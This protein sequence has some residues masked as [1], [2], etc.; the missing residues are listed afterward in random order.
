MVIA[1]IVSKLRD[2]IPLWANSSQLPGGNCSY[3]LVTIV[4]RHLLCFQVPFIVLTPWL[5]RIPH[6]WF[7]TKKHIVGLGGSFPQSK[8]AFVFFHENQFFN[9]KRIV[10]KKPCPITPWHPQTITSWTGWPITNATFCQVT[11]NEFVIDGPNVDKQVL[12]HPKNQLSCKN[13]TLSWSLT[14]FSQ[15]D[16]RNPVAVNC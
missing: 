15:P 13:W 11:K 1:T 6:P 12:C 14:K 10:N 7:V 4:A 8:G 2:F 16:D 9:W 3:N 5:I